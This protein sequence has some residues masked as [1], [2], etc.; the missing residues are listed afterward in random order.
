MT[1]IQPFFRIGQYTD[2]EAM[3]GCTVII[4]EEGATGGV[5]VRGGSPNTRDTDAL[6]SENNRK[7]VHA[8][9]LSGGSAFGLSASDG[10]VKFLESRQIGRDVGIGVVPNVSGASLFD[11]GIGN[12]GT[13]PDSTFGYRACEAAF[14]NE[15]FLAGNHGAGTGASVGN[16]NGLENAMKGGIGSHTIQHGELFVSAVVAVNAVGDIYDEEQQQFLAGARNGQEIGCSEAIFLERYLD[17][18]D[19]YSGNTVIGCVMT[20]ATFPKAK[21]NK[22]AD[23][24]HNGIARAVRPAHTTFDGDTM[25]VLCANQVEATFE[26]VSI[27]TVEAVRQA[28]LDGV[29]KAETYGDYLSYKDYYAGKNS[30]TFSE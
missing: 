19:M 3:T 11:L 8:V 7:V 6:K 13:R 20:N 27:L 28:I 25:F 4:A 16:I 17:L 15:P 10:V 14:R 2:E 9:T 21:V 23:I 1:A 24:S 26:A 30:Q 18:R 12:K 5:C 22:L 29:K